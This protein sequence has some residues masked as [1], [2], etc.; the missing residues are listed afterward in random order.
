[1]L[2]LQK[3][4]AALGGGEI[5]DRRLLCHNMCGRTP[6]PI[7]VQLSSDARCPPATTARRDE[8]SPELAA[9]SATGWLGHGYSSSTGEFERVSTV[10]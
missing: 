1:M 4:S 9:S 10:R 8:T 3:D 7:S 5:T 2:P 6:T